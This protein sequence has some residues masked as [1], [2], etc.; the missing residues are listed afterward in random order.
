[1][2]FLLITSIGISTWG[3]SIAVSA[4]DSSEIA[5]GVNLTQM[6][7]PIDEFA[8]AFNASIPAQ[9][10]V[11]W[12]RE[13]AFVDQ[14][15][16]PNL[17]QLYNQYTPFGYNWEF[18][19]DVQGVS[20]L[21]GVSWTLPQWDNYVTDAL[22]AFP[23]VHVW[24]VGNEVLSGQ[25]QY[26]NGYL[27]SGNLSQ[28]YFNMLRDT[29]N[30][31]KQHDA[32][33]TVI[34]FGGNDF[35]DPAQLSLY[36]TGS[37]A[38]ASYK[39]AAQVWANGADNY[40]DAISLHAYADNTGACWLLNE[41]PSYNGGTSKYT[42]QQLWNGSINAYEQL[43]GKPIWFTETGE[44]IDSP[45]IDQTPPII[46][47]SLQKQAAFL[48][49]TFTLLSSYS[50][51]RAIFWFKLTGP[52]EY[53]SNT[54]VLLYTLDDGLFNQDGTARPSTAVYQTFASTTIPNPTSSPTPQQ[55]PTPSTLPSASPSPSAKPT[56]SPS[57]S[58]PEL[59]NTAVIA[60]LV[61][62]VTVFVFF[63]MAIHKRSDSSAKTTQRANFGGGFGIKGVRR[64]SSPIGPAFPRTLYT[65]NNTFPFSF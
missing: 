15:Y 2:I 49:Q 51:T 26:N 11:S 61:A 53:L 38:D 19:F 52:S 44:P 23:D 1:M 50:F 31:V 59:Q 22:N 54:G 14:R 47:N 34:A 8:F 48:N 9:Y 42:I 41:T 12:L 32:S 5:Y 21:Y 10:G 37:F 6:H 27:A 65:E 43:T 36:N 63:K 16:G 57:P 30:L 18:R 64:S 56:N 55:S 13:A 4:A 28:A 7:P 17:T 35:F 29:Y 25:A 3:A 39:N 20:Q 58:I 60:V 45:P 24:E 33:D 62:S 40:C 46:S